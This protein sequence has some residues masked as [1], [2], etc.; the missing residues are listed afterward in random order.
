MRVAEISN[1]QWRVWVDTL[2]GAAIV[3][4]E[5]FDLVSN[6]WVDV[7]P[8]T[9]RNEA[10]RDSNSETLLTN[11]ASM[12][13]SSFVMAPYSNRI[14]HGDL[15]LAGIK[16]GL[17]RPKE[18]AI[19]GDVWWRPGFVDELKN[20][21]VTISMQTGSPSVDWPA[22]FDATV[23]YELSEDIF[24]MNLRLKNLSNKVF[25]FEGGF[26]PY[27]L[28]QFDRKY[29]KPSLFDGVLTAKVSERLKTEETGIPLDGSFYSGASDTICKQLVEGV[30]FAGDH[31]MIDD[32][33]NLDNSCSK[34]ATLDYSG[35]GVKLAFQAL[36]GIEGCVIY[37]PPEK[38]FDLEPVSHPNGNFANPFLAP[39]ESKDISFLIKLIRDS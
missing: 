37:N 38:Y 5:V 8:D 17:N 9:L 34:I 4:C 21:K 35:S 11:R 31:V 33:F 14:K 24:R 26:H 6:N 29:V 13:E 25:P 18:H 22:D 32:Y 27:F 28:K 20:E 15:Q 36:H 3:K 7:M 19:H 23:T 30:G 16:Y 10:A 1:S 39:G 2:Y 12:P